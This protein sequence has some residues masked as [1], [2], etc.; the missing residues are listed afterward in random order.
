MWNTHSITTT[1]FVIQLKLCKKKSTNQEA[2]NL[3]NYQ[4]I[5]E[6]YLKFRTH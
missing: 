3:N 6:K 4:M 1:A 5:V 2:E